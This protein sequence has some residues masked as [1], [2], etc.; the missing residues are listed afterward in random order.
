MTDMGT[1]RL[2]LVALL[3]AWTGAAEAQV[4]WRMPTEYPATAMPGEGLRIFAAA[5][6]ER[7]GGRVVIEPQFE[8]GREVSGAALVTA[9]AAG[10]F[11]AGDA[12]GGAL[13]SVNPLFGLSALPFLAN[14]L[15]DARRLAD[16][17]RDAYGRAFASRGLRLLYVVPWPASGI[18]S[19]RVLADS[20][21][22]RG[23]AIRTYDATSTDVLRRAGAAAAEIG[24]GEAM[25]KLRDGSLDAVLSSG[26]GGAG[27]R[28]W[29]VLT[30]FTAVDYAFPLSFAVATQGAHE[31]LAPDLRAAVD[32]AAAATEAQLWDLV[33]TRLRENYT[34]MRENG[35][36]I[37]APAPAA[38]GEALRQAAA[39]TLAAWRAAVPAGAAVLDVLSPR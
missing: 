14:S 3:V 30:R 18:W 28:L 11:E 35:V 32:A 25:P 1:W 27:R 5:V 37:V 33:E 34:R 20:E 15:A 21:G 9:L 2:A 13:G 36:E 6:A 12:F 17:A 26:D 23:L 29:E 10:R 19:K 22:L 16:L 8:G 39:P 38:L 24:F 4:R 31:A 7:G